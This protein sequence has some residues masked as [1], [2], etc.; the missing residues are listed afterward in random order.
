MFSSNLASR[1][2]CV[3]F[4]Y[5]I[6]LAV[7]NHLRNGGECAILLPKNYHRS[8]GD[9]TRLN[10]RDCN[11]D[12]SVK[13]GTPLAPRKWKPR[14]GI[15]SVCAS[16]RNTIQALLNCSQIEEKVPYEADATVPIVSRRIQSFDRGY[17]TGHK[18][19][20]GQLCLSLSLAKCY[21]FTDR[22]LGASSFRHFK[23]RGAELRSACSFARFRHARCKFMDDRC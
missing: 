8:N 15:G 18:L 11:Y 16:E 13:S 17:F 14:L 4:L 20:A 22:L 2:T 12:F 5:V 7:K 9:K 3:Y 10:F 23:V 6:K 1:C 21:R 19:T